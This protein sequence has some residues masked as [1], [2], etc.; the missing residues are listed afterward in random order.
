M[1]RIIMT[2]LL[3]FLFI[4]TNA[5]N[6]LIN[7]KDTMVVIT[8][9]ELVKINKIIVSEEYLRKTVE[10]QNELLNADSALLAEKDSII[11]YTELRE[12]KKEA[13]YI[14]QTA[15]LKKDLKKKKTLNFLKGSGIGA[16]IGFIIGIL[17]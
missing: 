6:L 12:Q 8:P 7:G 3:F 16:I 17:L 1:S 11:Q 4:P 9:E 5:Q 15:A 2:F 13:F 10:T 14:D